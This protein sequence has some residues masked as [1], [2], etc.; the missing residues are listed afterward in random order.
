MLSQETKAELLRHSLLV[1]TKNK[2]E[3][4][5]ERTNQVKEITND[6][7]RR[8]MR[9]SG[10]Y[11]ARVQET[12]EAFGDRSV[13]F[14]IATLK[15]LV[16]KSVACLDES[17]IDWIYDEGIK[18]CDGEYEHIRNSLR[19]LINRIRKIPEMTERQD[20]EIVEKKTMALTKL[21]RDKVI[22]K[23]KLAIEKKNVKADVSKAAQIKVSDEIPDF[24]KITSSS[25]LERILSERW[26]NA[27][28]CIENKA[29]V[30]A[31]VDVLG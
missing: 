27:V 4:I 7:S 14:F 22:E 23:G 28:I 21:E 20:S 30:S 24:S 29:F 10:M 2:E 31:I 8:G 16:N 12:Y 9:N 18:I 5:V 25:K 1:Y 11:F 6:F 17:D 19:D 26:K 13:G 15:E 3:F